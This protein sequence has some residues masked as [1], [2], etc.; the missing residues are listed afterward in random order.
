MALGLSS[1][2]AQRSQP[3]PPSYPGHHFIE[4]F[5]SHSNQNNRGGTN[6]WRRSLLARVG[7]CQNGPPWPL[8]L[9]RPKADFFVFSIFSFSE[10][11]HFAVQSPSFIQINLQFNLFG[12]SCCEG[13]RTL[14]SSQFSSF[15]FQKSFINFFQTSKVHRKINKTKK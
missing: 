8:G 14:K 3:Q 6:G 10:F 13:P 5:T 1:T 15:F 11:E 2:I 7:Q 12:K 9:F 4:P